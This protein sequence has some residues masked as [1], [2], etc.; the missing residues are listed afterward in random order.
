MKAGDTVS[1]EGPVDLDTLRL[2]EGTRADDSRWL[3]TRAQTF[4]D[5]S[6]GGYVEKVQI[7]RRVVPASVD[8]PD[9]D[10]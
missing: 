9:P 8:L 7:E 5:H 6:T 3:I 1:V 2:G 4:Y 10:V